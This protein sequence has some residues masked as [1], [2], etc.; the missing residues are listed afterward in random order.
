MRPALATLMGMLTLQ[1]CI[2]EE[3]SREGDARFPLERHDLLPM[4]TPST[5]QVAAGVVTGKSEALEQPI[6]FSHNIHAGMLGMNCEFCHSEARDSIHA[7]VPPVQ[8]C[9]NC[10]E[11]VKTDN[12]DVLTLHSYY[13]DEPP[14][15]VQDGPFGPIP[16]EEAHPIAWNKVHDLPDYVYFSHKRHIQGGL[17]CT[18]CHGQ[19]MMQGQPITPPPAEDAHGAADDHG[20]AKAKAGDHGAADDHAAP[21]AHGEPPATM[22]VMVRETSLQ[23]GWCLDC[24]AT[25]PSIDQNY[26]K[27]ADLRR[28]ELKDCWT[29]HK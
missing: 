18:E 15:R 21:A 14:C 13:C 23:M 16:P 2:V 20:K 27:D 29:C 3:A 10:H 24:H 7:G 17:D 28:A 9:M 12:P 25:H 5:G 1:A 6:P 26:G 19:I 8:M 22:S 4:Y 11:Y